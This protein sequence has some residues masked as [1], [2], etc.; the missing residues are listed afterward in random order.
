MP[1]IPL[2]PEPIVTRWLNG[3][4]LN[5]ALFYANNFE[6][7]RNVI[8]S[9]KDDAISVEKLKQLV[10]NNTVKCDLAF[11]KLHLSELSINLTNLESSNSELLESMNMFRKIED[12]LTN[13]PGPDGKKIKDKFMYVIEKNEGCKTIKSYYEVMSGKKDVNLDIT[14]TLLDS[15]KYA[16]ITSVDVERSFSLYKHI[17]SNRRFNF[18]EQN[19]EMYLIIN[20][21]SKK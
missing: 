15:F 8:D 16:S 9:L 13:I 1:G 2:P 19:L 5:A 10:Q 21:N 18:N 11:I 12:I 20:F 4:W 17:L 6:K 14:P 7:F 3:T